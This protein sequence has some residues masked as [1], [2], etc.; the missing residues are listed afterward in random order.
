[1]SRELHDEASQSLTVLKVGLA[2]LERDAGMPSTVVGRV[3]D[4][5]D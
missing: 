3:A 2:L 4:L 1:M 5:K